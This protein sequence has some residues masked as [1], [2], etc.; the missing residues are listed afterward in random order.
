MKMNRF[1]KAILCLAVLLLT[2]AGTSALAEAKLTFSPENPKVGEYVDVTVVPE[3]EGALGV[4]YVLSTLSGVV[5]ENKDSSTHYTASFR[6][7][8][9]A[10]YTLTAVIEYGK[11]DTE[12]VTVTIPVSGAAPVQEGTDVVYSQK[13]GWW[14]DKVY[15][16]K[17]HRSLEKAGCAIFALSHT[18]QRLGVEGAEIQPDQLAVRYSSMYIEGRG[19]DNEGLLKKAGAEYGFLTQSELIESERGIVTCLKRGDLMSFAI[20]LGHIAMADG[21]SEDGKMVH[22]VDSAPGATYERKDRFK[23]KGHIY[24][25]S[26]DGSFTEAETA[27]QLPGIRWFF[28]TG[29]YGGMAYWLD[30]HYCAYRGMRLVRRPWL[31]ADTGSG[32]QPVAA[33]EYAG[34]LVSKVSTGGESV[35]VPTKD[36]AWTTDGADSPQI[37]VVTNKKG[38]KLLDGDGNP[39]PGSNKPRPLGSMF[40]VLRADDDL[41]YICWK[42]TFCYISRKNVDLLPVRQEDFPTGIVSLN[43]KTAGTAK[44]AV[45]STPSGKGAKV[46]DWTIG[47]PV[48]VVEKGSEFTLVEG[49]G[50]RGWIQNK[51]LTLDSAE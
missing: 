27:D 5:C 31:K 25:Q 51:N 4:R 13:D 50:F 24:Y 34:A 26:E 8:E 11:K 40:I 36:L 7:R 45:R 16:K 37:A 46:T 39:L 20:A 6:P 9:E 10:E 29:E 28:E 48:A 14:H 42:D 32:L 15:N 18:L 1:G 35:R 2:L 3:R 44:V 49:K 23:T 12:S 33:L 21:I 30:L 47:T 41:C 43:G 17:H 22:V 38:A 19:T